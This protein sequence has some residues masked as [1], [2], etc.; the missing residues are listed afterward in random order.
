VLMSRARMCSKPG[1]W[2][3]EQRE[4]EGERLVWWFGISTIESRTGQRTRH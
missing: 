4:K 1:R 2:G 3:R